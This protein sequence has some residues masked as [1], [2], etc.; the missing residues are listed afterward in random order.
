M[1]HRDV[2]QGSM[3]NGGPSMVRNGLERLPGF[4]LK[5]RIACDAIQDK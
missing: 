1:V 3:S 2:V 4:V 5:R